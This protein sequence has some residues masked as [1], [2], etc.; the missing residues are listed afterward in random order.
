MIH[1]HP[2]PLAALLALLGAWSWLT[3]A[4]AARADEAK[5]KLAADAPPQARC[6][7]E[8]Y[9]EFLC[10][11]DAQA[12][13]W[14][15]GTRM[16]WDDGKDKTWAQTLD[17]ADPQDQTAQPYPALGAPLGPLEVDFEPGRARH[18][19]AFEKMYG[20]TAQEVGASLKT[21]RWLPRYVNAALP[22]TTVNGVADKLQA[23]SDELEL[24]PRALVEPIAKPSGSF[25]WRNVKGTDRKS[26][27][28]FAVA[29]DIGVERSDYWKWTKPDKDGKY[30]WR[31]RIPAEV[32]EVFERHGFVWGGR[33]YHFDTMHFEYR[34]ELLHPACRAK[35]AP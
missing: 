4:P 15:D 17:D 34:P 28:S 7:V 24:L 21:V 31:N 9:P 23:V 11:A 22:V 14:C 32:V 16:A 18:E 3:C 33:W 29:V 26:A 19:P 27:H 10:G 6:W 1:A 8:A 30:V 12:L 20:A 13:V 5:P 25:V 35:P 2:R